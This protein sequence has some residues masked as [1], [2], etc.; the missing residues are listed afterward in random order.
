MFLLN[1]WNYNNFSKV[2][3]YLWATR[4][5]N[6]SSL[7]VNL[8]QCILSSCVPTSVHIV[9]SSFGRINCFTLYYFVFWSSVLRRNTVGFSSS[10]YY[11]INQEIQA[12]NRHSFVGIN[13][14]RYWRH[15]QQPSLISSN[16]EA[17]YTSPSNKRHW[18]T[19]RWIKQLREVRESVPW[20]E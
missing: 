12:G 3:Y 10:E 5:L 7:F 18:A 1:N 19:H 8:D 20:T 4:H 15:Q 9:W 2:K 16:K 14:R 6:Y 11:G 13:W 17:S